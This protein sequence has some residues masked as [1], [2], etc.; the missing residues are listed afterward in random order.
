MLLIKRRIGEILRVEL[1]DFTA[2]AKSPV[3]AQMIFVHKTLLLIGGNPVHGDSGVVLLQYLIVFIK[4][5][6]IFLCKAHIFRVGQLY[7]PHLNTL[8]Y[9]QADEPSI[10]ILELW[11]YIKFIQHYFVAAVKAFGVSGYVPPSVKLV[12]A[13]LLLVGLIAL[14]EAS[15]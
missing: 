13:L 15:V 1:T 2:K 8:I 3:I 7:K 12:Q 6:P 4:L 11:V 14:I 9:A 5:C 10:V